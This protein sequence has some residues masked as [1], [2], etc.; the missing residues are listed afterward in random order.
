MAHDALA[1]IFEETDQNLQISAIFVLSPD[2]SIPPF[3]K[4]VGV[5]ASIA[6]GHLV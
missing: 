2:E 1:Q 4:R 5:D 6:D 3:A